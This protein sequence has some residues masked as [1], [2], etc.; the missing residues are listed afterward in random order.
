LEA[1]DSDST[2]REQAV[3]ARGILARHARR[4]A[5]DQPDVLPVDVAIVKQDRGPVDLPKAR[6]AKGN[7]KAGLA[8]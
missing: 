8:L 4:T 5:A 2:F 6:A 1:V 3:R 7:E